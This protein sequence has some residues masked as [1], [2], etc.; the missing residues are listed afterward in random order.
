MQQ[1]NAWK[2]EL[3]HFGSV[4][5][6][7]FSDQPPRTRRWGWREAHMCFT[8]RKNEMP[9]TRTKFLQ[10]RLSDGAWPWSHQGSISV[11]NSFKHHY[12]A[13]LFFAWSLKFWLATAESGGSR[14]HWKEGGLQCLSVGQPSYSSSTLPPPFGR[15]WLCLFFS[16]LWAS[17]KQHQHKQNYSED[18][19]GLWK[20]ATATLQ[21][22]PGNFFSNWAKKLSTQKAFFIS[23][24]Q[25]LLF[26]NTEN[27]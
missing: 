9:N 19:Q 7:F 24:L 1:P 3:F 25:K 14:Y 13:S 26:T 4:F 16:S 2:S 21:L 6:C 23:P 22:G 17:Y 11:C 27:E 20:K 12:K 5:V 15:Q 10:E 8:K 18:R